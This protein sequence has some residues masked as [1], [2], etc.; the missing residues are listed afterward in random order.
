ML[1]KL[2]F[3]RNRK[4]SWTKVGIIIVTV[5]TA[6]LM[7]NVLPDVVD[8]WLKVVIALGTVIGGTGIRDAI[9]KI[10]DF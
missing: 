10:K 3:N 5:A 2:L 7:N 1:Q 4:I 6:L 8:G 9:D